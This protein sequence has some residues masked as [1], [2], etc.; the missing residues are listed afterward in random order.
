M[1]YGSWWVFIS[2]V[3]KLLYSLHVYSFSVYFYLTMLFCNSCSLRLLF[4]F[5]F[6][7]GIVIGM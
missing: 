2:L 1:G 7:H 3:L 6:T 5:A 4:V